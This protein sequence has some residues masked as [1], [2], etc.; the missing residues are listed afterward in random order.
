M[1][2]LVTELARIRVMF[3]QR[4]ICTAIGIN[5]D[6]IP[7]AD[8][9]ATAGKDGEAAPTSLPVTHPT[10]NKSGDHLI[11]QCAETNSFH[12]AQNTQTGSRDHG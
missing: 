8:P 4:A 6:F 7:G 11:N 3:Q 5:P 9:T 2:E 12:A 1:L 10:G